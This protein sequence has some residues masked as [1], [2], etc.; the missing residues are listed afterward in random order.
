VTSTKKK[1]LNSHME[2]EALGIPNVESLGDGREEVWKELINKLAWV[3]GSTYKRPYSNVKA[4][5]R[6]LAMRIAGYVIQGQGFPS[7][8]AK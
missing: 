6:Q 1:G 5:A 4:P 7:D 3:L 2:A 8:L